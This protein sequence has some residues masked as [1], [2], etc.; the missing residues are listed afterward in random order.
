[1]K[2]V[3]PVD[4]A[5]SDAGFDGMHG[6]LSASG[7]VL[8]VHASRRTPPVIMETTEQRLVRAGDGEQRAFAEVYDATAAQVF[9]LVLRIVTDRA[10][11]EDVT[12]EVYLEAW[13]HAKRFDPQRGTA[14]TWLLQIALSRAV[15]RV[16]DARMQRARDIGIGIRNAPMPIDVIAERTETEAARACQALAQLG[17]LGRGLR[18]A[19]RDGVTVRP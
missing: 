2:E 7:T 17:A 3:R 15:D 19:G 5:I 6:E 16:R 18:I 1:M 9:G 4:A 12:Q 14:I 10:L 8:D 13:R 11:A